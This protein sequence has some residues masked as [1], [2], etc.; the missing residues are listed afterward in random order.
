MKKS[1]SLI[2]IVITVFV[3]FFFFID[4]VEAADDC[5]EACEDYD[6]ARCEASP[7]L[8]DPNCGFYDCD[9]DESLVWISTG[10]PLCCLVVDCWCYTCVCDDDCCP[11]GQACESGECTACSGEG[12]Q[13]EPGV[14]INCCQGRGL[15]CENFVC[16]SSGGIGDV[17]IG[18]DIPDP[19]LNLTYPS[20]TIDDPDGEPQTYTLSMDP[21]TP[22]NALI[23]WLYYFIVMIGGLAAFV[24]MVWGGFLWLTAAGNPS[25]ISEAKDRVYSALIGL[26][27]I[28]LSWLIL[29]TINP[30]L[31]ILSV[32]ALD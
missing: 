15:I 2:L 25:R 22:M 21:V 29:N 9:A 18:E 5:D 28:L 16:I 6:G 4:L 20:I 32:P 19:E 12:E 14:G 7:N 8:E 11:S 3:G 24:G 10:L 31:I 26:L 13:C 27:I 30:Q 17:E 23:A 1:F